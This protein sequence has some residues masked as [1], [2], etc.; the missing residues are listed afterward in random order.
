MARCAVMACTVVAV[1]SVK[2]LN[3]AVRSD[4]AVAADSAGVLDGAM[5]CDGTLLVAGNS[6]AAL[7]LCSAEPC[8]AAMCPAAPGSVVLCS[9]AMCSAAPCSADPCPA[10]PCVGHGTGCCDTV[11][12]DSMTPAIAL[13]WAAPLEI[14]MSTNSD[15]V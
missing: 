9:A 11:T 14:W 4:G 1:G 8:S 6:V 2:V 3:D 12:P 7:V 10:V 15:D 5:C 13:C